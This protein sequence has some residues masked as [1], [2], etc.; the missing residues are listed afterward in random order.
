LILTIASLL[1]AS[2]L[3]YF[4]K[5]GSIN[6]GVSTLIIGLNRPSASISLLFTENAFEKLIG[7]FIFA[8]LSPQPERAN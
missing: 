4:S 6:N 7:V 3:E 8:M 5:V 1:K 2:Y